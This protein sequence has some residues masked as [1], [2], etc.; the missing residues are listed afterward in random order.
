M[1]AKS[2]ITFDMNMRCSQHYGGVLG[3]AAAHNHISLIPQ[4]LHLGA[5]VVPYRSGVCSPLLPAVISGSKEAVESLLQHGADVN[6]VTYSE[7][8]PE[9]ALNIAV[10]G[11]NFDIASTLLAYGADLH[12]R[13]EFGTALDYALLKRRTK[14]ARFLWDSHFPESEWDSNHPASTGRTEYHWNDTAT[15]HRIDYHAEIDAS[16]NHDAGIDLVSRDDNRDADI[17]E[18]YHESNIWIA[19]ANT[20]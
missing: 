9:S 1:T 6:A 5:E 11:N 18:P 8:L 19:S 14:M 15:V 16:S 12:Y 3:A 7:V 20:I 4:I 13:N 2:A 17:W 10:S